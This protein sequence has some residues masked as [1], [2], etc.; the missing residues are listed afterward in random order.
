MLLIRRRLVHAKLKSSFGATGS[1]SVKFSRLVLEANR[2][3][4][5]LGYEARELM[6]YFS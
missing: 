4:S 1:P 6:A 2:N 3:R 5:L